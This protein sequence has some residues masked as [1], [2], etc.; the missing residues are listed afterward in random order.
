MLHKVKAETLEH[1]GGAHIERGHVGDEP[2]GAMEFHDPPHDF[3]PGSNAGERFEQL[4]TEYTL[5]GEE[6]RPGELVV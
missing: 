3:R 2:P 4:D 6:R 5:P 1:A